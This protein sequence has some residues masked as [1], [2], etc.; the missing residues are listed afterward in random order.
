MTSVAKSEDG[1]GWCSVSLLW[2]SSFFFFICLSLL[3]SRP[4]YSRGSS[5]ANGPKRGVAH[6]STSPGQFPVGSR[7]IR[8][9]GREQEIK[10]PP[11]YRNLVYLFY[12]F[13]CTPFLSLKSHLEN[14]YLHFGIRRRVSW[15]LSLLFFPWKKLPTP[16]WFFFQRKVLW[17]RYRDRHTQFSPFLFFSFDVESHVTDL[18]CGSRPLDLCALWRECAQLVLTGL[19]FF[20][21]VFLG[22]QRGR[23]KSFSAET[24]TTQ[25]RPTVSA[26]YTSAPGYISLAPLRHPLTEW[27]LIRRAFTLT[28]PVRLTTLSN[29]L[30]P[31]MCK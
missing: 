24:A 8:T 3:P 2:T 29:G 25:P 16:A 11:K 20:Y 12:L 28:A 23:V 4:S 15:F 19:F 5:T 6:T 27:S 30:A 21:F 13:R 14:A 31:W 9:T 10:S 7:S 22:R 1:D 17:V 26:S 18:S